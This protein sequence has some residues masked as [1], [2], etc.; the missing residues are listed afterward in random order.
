MT[1]IAG[2]T[3]RRRPLRATVAV[4][5]VDFNNGHDDY[6]AKYDGLYV[7]LVRARQ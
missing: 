4:P 1:G 3:G 5:G 2:L 7:R 6:G